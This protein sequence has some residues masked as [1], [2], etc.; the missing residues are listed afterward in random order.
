MNI[1]IV[2]TNIKIHTTWHISSFRQEQIV[3]TKL[4]KKSY[5][6]SEQYIHVIPCGCW[7][8]GEAFAKFVLEVLSTLFSL[9]LPTL[10][11]T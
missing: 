2:Y 5:E 9:I 8:M 3:M 6:K 1:K 11:A 4:S 7:W 10:K